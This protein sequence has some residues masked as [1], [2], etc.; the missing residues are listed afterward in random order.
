MTTGPV[1]AFSADILTT[2]NGS[3]HGLADSRPV[4]LHV[5]GHEVGNA[6]DSESG[7]GLDLSNSTRPGTVIPAQPD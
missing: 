5:T 7:P 4:P 1:P 2:V 3:G 6:F